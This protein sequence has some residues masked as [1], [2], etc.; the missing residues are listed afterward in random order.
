MVQGELIVVA[1]KASLQKISVFLFAILNIVV[2]IGAVM[3][4]VEGEA[5][6]FD[7]IP[8]SIYWAIVTI[9]TVG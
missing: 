8:R 2:I 3:Y 5:S 1:I 6:G 4:V 9:T 7:S